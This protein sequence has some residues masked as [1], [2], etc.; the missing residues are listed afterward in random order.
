MP[1]LRAARSSSR[2][3]LPPARGAEP[4]SRSFY[5]RNSPMRRV[6]LVGLVASL[7]LGAI[8]VSVTNDGVRAKRSEQD[9]SLQ[10]ATS[11]EIA[12]IYGGERQT[13]TALS[14]MLGNPA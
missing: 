14:L 3:R 6:A 11:A 12:L 5:G 2:L 7:L 13:Q 9:R 1:A 10:D 4:S 8:A